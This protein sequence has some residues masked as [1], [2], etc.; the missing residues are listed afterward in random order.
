MFLTRNFARGLVAFIVTL[1]LTSSSWS[2]VASAFVRDGDTL[3]PGSVAA[4]SATA[5]NHAG[6]YAAIANVDADGTTI[7]TIVG[8]ASGG[9]VS[10][11]LQEAQY[12]D[13]VQNNF[14]GFFGFS[15]AG[16]PT[17]SALADNFVTGVTSLDG[18]WSG[19]TLIQNEGDEIAGAPGEF[20]SFNS[21]PGVTAGGTPY[22]V[23]GLTD[24]VGGGSIDR[25]LFY[26]GNILLRGGDNVGVPEPVTTGSGI[27]FDFRFSAMGTN[28]ISPI[29]VASA[30]S[31]DLVIVVN[32]SAISPGGNVMREGTPIPISLGANGKDSWDNFDFMGITESGDYL[33]TGDTDGALDS[34]EFVF[35]NGEFVM[36]EGDVVGG[37]TTSGSIEGGF[38]NEDGDWSVIWDV[39]T[40]TGSVEALIVN[41]QLVLMGGDAVDW[42]NDG[43]ITAADDGAVLD[44]F[45]GISSLSMSDRNANGEVNLVFTADV[46]NAA[47]ASAEGA[48]TLTM[49]VPEPASAQMLICALLSLWG[50]YR[51]T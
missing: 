24:T 42:D 50:L 26:D 17:Y 1:F 39:E 47:G 6:G 44:V 9:P 41:G 48:F 4:V 8:T 31:N 3:G 18:V 49:V 45:T 27:D 13:L 25:A 34:D 37:F 5:V 10:V 32:G 40:D 19:T 20:S 51:R 22:W 11:L 43:V 29:D 23:G 33:V 21:R 7:S 28:F 15:D 30:A 16:V 14:E 36:R 38:L 12:G 2:Q 46:I 35:V